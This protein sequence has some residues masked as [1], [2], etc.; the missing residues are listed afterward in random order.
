M[1][2][3]FACIPI[4]FLPTEISFVPVP[5]RL[6]VAFLVRIPILSSPNSNEP[7]LFTTAFSFVTW[8][9]N[10]AIVLVLSA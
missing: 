2:E 10:P 7:L 1:L 9:L 4:P 8:L 5:V 3:S 6:I